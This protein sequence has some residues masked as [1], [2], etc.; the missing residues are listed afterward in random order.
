MK[1]KDESFDGLWAMASVYHIPNKEILD[2]LKEFYRVLTKNGLLYVSV[3]EG[4]EKEER[5]DIA[6]GETRTFYAYKKNEMEK[7]F[8]DA[9]FT[10][11]RCE[12]NQTEDR[13]WLEV[14][15]RKD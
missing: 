5:K 3:Y 9:G 12:I 10:I 4:E 1:F 8:E 15:A 11:I 6:V 14:Y 7:N 13:K 2:T